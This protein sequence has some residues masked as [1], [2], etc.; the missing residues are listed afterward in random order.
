MTQIISVTI[1][2]LVTPKVV[3]NHEL[4]FNKPASESWSVIQCQELNKDLLILNVIV[5]ETFA[6]V[7]KLGSKL[8]IGEVSKVSRW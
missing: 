8:T 6:S 4:L 1:I 5:A 2:N 3:A 7:N